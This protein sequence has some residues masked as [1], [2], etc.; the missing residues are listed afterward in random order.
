MCP[1]ANLDVLEKKQFY[2][3]PGVGAPTLAHQ[4]GNHS[5]QVP[6]TNPYCTIFMSHWTVHI[7]YPL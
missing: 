6:D 2:P 1:R 3:H 5:S 7:P 4:L